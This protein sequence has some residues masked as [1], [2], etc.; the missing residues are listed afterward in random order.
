MSRRIVKFCLITIG[1]TI[2]VSCIIGEVDGI[3]RAAMIFSGIAFVYAGA[4][5]K[6]Y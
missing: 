5:F 1:L 2:L 4:Y 6:K 3:G